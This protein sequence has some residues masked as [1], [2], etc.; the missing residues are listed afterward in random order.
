MLVTALIIILLINIINALFMGKQYWNL[1]RNKASD[2][3]YEELVDSMMRI[4]KFI[5][6][7]SLVLLV[8][9]YFIQR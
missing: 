9:I 3:R 1:K 7:L 4:D 5:I 6:P 8:V 2:K